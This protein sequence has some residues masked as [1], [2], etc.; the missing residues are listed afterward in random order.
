MEL[1]I[2]QTKESTIFVEDPFYFKSFTQLHR[3][4]PVMKEKMEL[5]QDSLWIGED[6]VMVFIGATFK[7]LPDEFEP[8]SPEEYKA[9]FSKAIGKL[10]IVEDSL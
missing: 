1:K 7:S 5:Y 10:E 4:Y 3:V 9:A 8:I 2:K 6:A